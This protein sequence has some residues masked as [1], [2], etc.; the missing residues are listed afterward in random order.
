M[1]KIKDQFIGL[2]ANLQFLYDSA[3]LFEKA[4]QELTLSGVSICIFISR[5]KY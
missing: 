4:E 2:E 5:D 1:N 3:K